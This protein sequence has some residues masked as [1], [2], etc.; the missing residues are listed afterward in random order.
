MPPRSDRRQQTAA[1]LD[2][3]RRVVRALR[4]AAGSAESATGLTAA[5]LFVLQAIRAAPGGSLTEIAARTMTDRTSVRA[6]VDR[7]AERGL[8]DRRPS[9]ADRRRAELVAT[10]AALTML[11]RAPHP[12]TRRLL[13]GLETMDERDLRALARGLGALVAAMHLDGEPAAMLFEDQPVARPPRQPAKAAARGPAKVTPKTPARGG[14]KPT[15]RARGGRMAERTTT[16]RSTRG[17]AG[18][19][20]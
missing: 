15:T 18:R 19:R 11:A 9:A 7:L 10:P 2:G 13:D 1:A 17:A 3:V 16:R 12:P 20:P 5:Q 8:V 14:A 4:V 6:V